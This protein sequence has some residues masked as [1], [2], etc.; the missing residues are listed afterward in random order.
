[1]ESDIKRV[2]AMIKAGANV[3]AQDY[4]GKLYFPYRSC[5]IG[6]VFFVFVL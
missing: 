2:R 6:R 1:M 4:A 3:N 5:P